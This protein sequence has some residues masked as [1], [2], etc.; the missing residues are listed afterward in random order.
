V[1]P[2]ITAS[3]WESFLFTQES[4]HLLQ[5]KAW[6]D[7]KSDFGWK[8]EYVQSGDCGAQILFRSFPLGFSLA[9]VPRGPLGP[10]LPALLSDLD[11]ICKKHRAFAMKVEPDENESVEKMQRL[12]DQSFTRSRHTIQPRTTLLVGLTGDEDQI[13]ARMHQKTRYNIRLAMRKEV[14]TRPWEDLDAFGRMIHETADR[15]AFG[16]HTTVYY[17][18]AYELFHPTGHC[19]LFVAEVEETPLAA[20][21]VFAY[22]PRAWYLYGASTNLER[23]RM[24]T[25]LL[26]WE[27]MKWAKRR[28]CVSYDLWGVPD[29]NLETLE[30]DFTSRQDDLWGVYRFKRGFGGNLVHSI[31]AW[32]RVYLP[33]IYRVYQWMTS[34]LRGS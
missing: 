3:Q 14:R 9:Y 12:L 33:P 10:W 23:N 17:R 18:R 16:A 7:L 8:V 22:G 13:L 32:D 28:G 24:P 29:E 31:G 2:S 15:D 26:Q 1:T 19:E 5:S 25:Y 30:R 4:A 20:V 6:G 11:V 34:L 27:A 21:M